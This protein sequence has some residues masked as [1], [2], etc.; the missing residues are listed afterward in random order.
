MPVLSDTTIAE[1]LSPYIGCPSRLLPG[2]SAYLD[3]LLR[4]NA[5]MNL[6]AIR[7]PEEIVRR[8][9]GESL[10]AA[11]H[12]GASGMEMPDTLLDLGSGAGFPGLPIAMLRPEISV[13]LAES[14]N[15]K[16]AFLRE[17]VRVLEVPNA[18]VWAA[19]AESLPEDR[20]FHTVTLRAV[21]AMNAA[22][23]AAAP[24]AIRKMVLLTATPPTLP[25]G[26]TA[27]APIPIPNTSASVLLRAVRG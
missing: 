24:R 26:F 21:D 2:L 12:L 19:R 5:R 17:A 18:E 27:E 8:H 15:K 7:T 22:I 9:F 25:E 23:A 14:Q 11:L 10:F 1:L 16:A 3:L 20:R 4:W 13:T 6:T